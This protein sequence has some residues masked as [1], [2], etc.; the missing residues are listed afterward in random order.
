MGMKN[1]SNMELHISAVYYVIR[2]KIKMY[3]KNT[4]F[5]SF[6]LSSL[7]RFSSSFHQF[8]IFIS[9]FIFI[10]Y[11]PN[12]HN[13]KFQNSESIDE[14]E[15]LRYPICIAVSR[16]FS[17]IKWNCQKENTKD[18][19]EFQCSFTWFAENEQKSV[20]FFIA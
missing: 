2:I 16:N 12:L 15:R 6:R 1:I 9:N 3:N 10:F 17:K 11:R 20:F 14:T 19:K 18:Q 4:L 5:H 7:F 8:S 13:R